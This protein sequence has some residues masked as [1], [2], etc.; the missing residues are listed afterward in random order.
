MLSSLENAYVALTEPP[1]PSMDENWLMT[2]RAIALNPL[3]LYAGWM[4]IVREDFDGQTYWR[5]YLKA[6]FQD[7]S[8]GAP[9]MQHPWNLNARYDGGPFQL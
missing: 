5:L 3:P 6:R 9:L 8:Q 2:G 4:A 7:G 1:T